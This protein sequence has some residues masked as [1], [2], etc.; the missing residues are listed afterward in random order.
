MIMV[1]HGKSRRPF[2]ACPAGTADITVVL[3]GGTYL[4]VECK[5]ETGRLRPEQE[6]F[7]DRLRGVGGL[8]MVV[9]SAKDLAQGLAM[10]GVKLNVL[11]RVGQ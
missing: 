6:N 11:P 2:R 1:G 5:S 3:P 4:G 7:R 9:R 10:Q 8:Y